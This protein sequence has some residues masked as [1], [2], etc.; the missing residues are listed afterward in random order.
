MRQVMLAAVVVGVSGQ[1]C[2]V[3]QH[4]MPAITLTLC[5]C[6]CVCVC[7]WVGVVVSLHEIHIHRLW[8]FW[9]RRLTTL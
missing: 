9:Y 1:N 4:V 2:Q 7:V 5:V 3:C 6:V 8:P